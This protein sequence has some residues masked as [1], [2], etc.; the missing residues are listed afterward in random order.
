MR[1][2]R[3]ESEP[4]VLVLPVLIEKRMTGGRR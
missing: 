4:L 1:K 2:V 3:V